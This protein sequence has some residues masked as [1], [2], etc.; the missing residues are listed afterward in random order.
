MKMTKGLVKFTG[1][2]LCGAAVGAI[3]AT[4]ASAQTDEIIV[5]AT[6]REE[7]V[8]DVPLAITAVS[9]EFVRDVNLDDVKDLVTF[10]PGVTELL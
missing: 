10:T 5:T 6:K 3:A 2:L 8:R 9:G 7:S 1:R 4:A